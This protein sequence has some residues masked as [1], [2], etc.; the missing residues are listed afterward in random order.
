MTQWVQEAIKGIVIVIVS[1]GLGAVVGQRKGS[2]QVETVRNKIHEKIGNIKD[3][4]SCLEEDVD[5]LQTEVNTIENSL[6]GSEM[7]NTDQGVVGQIDDLSEKISRIRNT[8]GS[9]EGKI[10]K[11][12]GEEI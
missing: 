6:Y 2:E 1:G 9:I 11:L 12:N 10:D 4:F 5:K 8:L 3:Q 7:D